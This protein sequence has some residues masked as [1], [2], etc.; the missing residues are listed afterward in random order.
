M[1]VWKTI[2]YEGIRFARNVQKNAIVSTFLQLTVDG[3]SHDVSRLQLVDEALPS[4][5]H[6]VFPQE[7]LTAI[8]A[9]GDGLWGIAQERL[10][11]VG[12]E[13][14]DFVETGIELD[15]GFITFAAA[16]DSTGSLWLAQELPITSPPTFRLARLDPVT[17]SLVA[18]RI[19]ASFGPRGLAIAPGCSEDA[20][21]PC[22]LGGRFRA[23]ARWKDFDGNEGAGQVVPGGSADSALF[24]FFEPA[25]WEVL[26][27]LVD[28]CEVNGHFWVFV[29]G[30]T[31]VEFELT[32]TDLVTGETFEASNP[33]GRASAAVT[34]TTAFATCGGES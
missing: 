30:T 33:L 18:S 28:G 25:N 12:T 27:K 32:V 11:E 3:A 34:D 26:V 6:E 1:D 2:F 4:L 5:I 13:F 20:T 19:D 14:G 17:R 21:R 31:D 23:K 8:A 10:V 15:S 24:W 16:S 7:D 22:L 9:N 29:A